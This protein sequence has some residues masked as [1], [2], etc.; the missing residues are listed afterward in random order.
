MRSRYRK[1]VCNMPFERWDPVL[2]DHGTN[3]IISLRTKN[4]SVLE[5]CNL[6]QKWP[7]RGS[8]YGTTQGPLI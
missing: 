7:P 4:V 3:E 8:F 1:D 2:Y 6:G 5:N